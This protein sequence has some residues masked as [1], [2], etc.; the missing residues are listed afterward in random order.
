MIVAG[1]IIPIRVDVATP[2]EAI[3][4]RCFME[5]LRERMKREFPALLREDPEL[6]AFIL[7][8]TRQ[9]FAGRVET[10]DRFDRLLAELRQDREAQPRTWEEQNHKWWEYNRE[11]NLKREEQNRKREESK[12]HFDRVHE[13]IMAMARKHERAIGALGA[14]WGMQSEATFRNALAGALEVTERL[15]IE[16]YSDSEDVGRL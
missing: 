4:V 3:D 8:L 13:E 5:S 2:L 6:R 9:E 16:L 1:R 14:R 7:D 12:A 10:Q 11:Q 15:G